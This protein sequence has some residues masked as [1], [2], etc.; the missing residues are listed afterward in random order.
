[1]KT[2]AG[3]RPYKVSTIIGM[4]N[5]SP[6]EAFP[7][8]AP[9]E[10]PHDDSQA[11]SDFATSLAGDAGD[12][13]AKESAAYP[14]RKTPPAPP[15]R[16]RVEV[17]ATDPQGRV[18]GGLYP[19]RSFG[20]YGGGIDP[21]E[22][23]EQAA[24]REFE[25]EA[26]Q[27]VTGLRPAQAEP[28]ASPWSEA[29]ADNPVARAKWERRAK[30]FPGG[31]RTQYYLGQLGEQTGPGEKAPTPQLKDFKFYG[32][33]EA[34]SIQEKAL[35]GATGDDERR[36]R[37]RL[38]VLK[39][40][41]ALRQGQLKKEAKKVYRTCR[42]EG[43]TNP[44]TKGVIWADGRG[45][46][47]S[48]DDHVGYWKGKLSDVVAVRNY[49]PDAPEGK[50]LS[51][52]NGHSKEGSLQTE[53]KLRRSSVNDEPLAV[54]PKV[55]ES[56]KVRDLGDESGKKIL[57]VD[58]AKVR[59]LIDV[60]FALGGNSARY[61]YVPDDEIWIENTGD[62]DDM[63]ATARHE[64]REESLMRKGQTYDNAHS[65][66][67]NIEGKERLLSRSEA[68]DKLASRRN[69]PIGTIETVETRPGE[70]APGIAGDR[71]IRSIPRVR[72]KAGNPE[73]T[74]SLSM[75]PAAK[76]GD[77]HDLRLVDPKGRAHSWA[78]Q[79]V[80]DPGKSTYAVQ[81]PTHSGAYAL[82]TQPFTIPA[83]Y[84]ATRPG[85][86]IEPKFVSPVEIVE[87]GNDKVRFLKHDGQQTQEFV[88]RK[89]T[90]SLMGARPLWA[91]HNATKTR[92]TAAGS[93][94]PAYKPKYQ[95]VAPEAIDLNDED[96]IMTPK[97]DGAHVLV[98]LPG[99]PNKFARVYSYRPTARDTGLIEHTF[100][101]P[102][103]QKQTAVV[104][105]NTMIRAECWAQ[106]KDGKP[107]P[108]EQL[109]GLL[110]AG[111]LNSRKKQ[112]ELGIQ[113]KL[114]GIDVVRADGKNY[115][116]KPYGDKLQVLE[117]VRKATKGWIDTPEVA[118]T[119]DQKKR[120]LDQVKN[121]QHPVTEEG[122]VLQRLSKA[123]TPI[124]AKFKPDHDVYV[125]GVFSKPKGQARG[126][127]GGLEYSLTPGGPT[128]GRVG[129]G[130][131]HVTRK[132]MLE[133]P[134]RY[135]GRVAK[136]Q[137]TRSQERKD[138]SQLKALR[139]P[140]FKGWHIDKTDPKLMEEDHRLQ[141]EA[142]QVAGV[143]ADASKIVDTK[144][145]ADTA[146]KS[147]AGRAVSGWA[148]LAGESSNPIVGA[149]AGEVQ[150]Y[151]SRLS[152]RDDGMEV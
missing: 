150:K 10:V 7:S 100:K 145:I 113:L 51:P 13:F 80:P 136:V 146:M 111:V 47:H 73:W 78:F 39:E 72:P 122:V 29:P 69:P 121:Q 17:F 50:R 32:I 148:R 105:K 133:N 19:D 109:G 92:N 12:E 112:Q 81:Q 6:S 119:P 134:D 104:G 66:V 62:Q 21:G 49:D 27:K 74:A 149:G 15:M 26:G 97:I 41:Q 36:L 107:V 82:K 114:T 91:L 28:F 55:I 140:S 48:C 132:D 79:D 115:E 52:G 130:F 76:R 1:M 14:F 139:A 18:P 125:T 87:A 42:K 117:R 67:S 68:I 58:G 102:G 4:G 24:A 135:V 151:L 35:Q 144:A 30:E 22:A 131:D 103:F 43:C 83:G 88:A 25:E 65:A 9:T 86:H 20:T 23:P 147:R 127:A 5:R 143:L 40:L 90:N 118:I 93:K 138:T 3:I 101:F 116:N 110:N 124:K 63:A 70:F 128:V 46:V 95:E 129:T 11:P 75:H 77:H 98:D 84:G 53:P 142:T 89:L 106:G 94:I 8:G 85:A 44:A 56:V 126:H 152:G 120:M 61:S 54:D 37:S 137:A 34:I 57:L 96:Q 38:E 31:H 64:I 16:Q 2:R 33:P 71:G 123:E 45:V 141:K 59:D 108:S 99:D 60:D